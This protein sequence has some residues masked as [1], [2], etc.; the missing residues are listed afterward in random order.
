[1]FRLNSSLKNILFI[2]TCALLALLVALRGDTR[3]TFNYLQVYRGLNEFPWN[4]IAFQ[5][6]YLMD[7]GFGLLAGLIKFSGLPPEFLFFFISAMTFFSIARASTT[8]GLE[9]WSTFP[10]YLSTFFLTQQLMQIRQ[11][12][13]IALAFWAIAILTKSSKRL[14]ISAISLTG[15]LFHAVSIIPVVIGL[16]TN[17][18]IPNQRSINN[19]LWSLNIFAITV[20]LCWAISSMDLFVTAE[21]ISVYVNDAEHGTPRGIFELANVRAILMAF[22]F[23]AFRPRDDKTYFHV[24]MFL[25]SIYVVHLG[26]RIGFIDFAILSGRIGSSLGF[27]EI[28]LLPLMLRD[29]I[30]QPLFRIMTICAYM[31][32]HFMVGLLIQLPYLID[33]Y[34]VKIL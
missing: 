18:F 6:E 3:D 10:Y 20:A 15:F 9:A 19:W 33:D 21:R 7:W 1:M 23:V 26:I 4:P 30:R 17:H 31:S 32:L 13:G 8:F 5:E 16:V 14:L 25:L 34:F 22:T 12:L 29:R 11:G 27:A 28:F 24:Y 2:I